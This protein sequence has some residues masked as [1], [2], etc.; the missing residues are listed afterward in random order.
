MKRTKLIDRPL[1]NYTRGEEIFNMVSHIVGGALGVVALTLCVVFAAMKGD[2]WG[3]VGS[4]IYGASLILLYSMSSIYHGLHKGMGKKVMQV[5]DHCTIY[6]LIGGTYTP[7]LLTVIREH[8]PVW[9]WVLFGIVW[10]LAAMAT[11]LTAI[12]L[13]KYSKLSM[14]CYIGMGWSIL[15]AWKTAVEAIPFAGILFILL[16]G[17]AYTVGAVIYS[18]GKKH[19]YMHSLFHLFV[20]AGSIL[21]FF[22]IFFYV[23]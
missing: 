1:P 8:S 23:I 7:I 11:T 22:G 19:R 15:I 16:G 14:A 21:Q 4:A 13:K 12:D 6:F 2:A 20:V 5:L 18:I 3:V 17:V 9:A 10:G